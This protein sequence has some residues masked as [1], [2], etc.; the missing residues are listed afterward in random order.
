MLILSTVATAAANCTKGSYYN[1]PMDFE[2]HG[3]SVRMG[4]FIEREDQIQ[5]DPLNA[6][7]WEFSIHF[8]P[9]SNSIYR[10]S[11]KERIAEM[12]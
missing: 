5:S 7:N 12:E 8:L 1:S 6:G 4:E 2:K 3:G 9:K 10:N 11:T